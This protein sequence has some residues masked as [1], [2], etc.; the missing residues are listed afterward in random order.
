MKRSDY[1]LKP[2]LNEIIKL[3]INNHREGFIQHINN[4]RRMLKEETRRS[5]CS[6]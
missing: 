6:L 1:A 4:K 3:A 5:Q 2:N